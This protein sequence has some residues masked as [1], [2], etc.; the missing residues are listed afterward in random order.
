MSPCGKNLINC[1]ILTPLDGQQNCPQMKLKNYFSFGL[2]HLKNQRVPHSMGCHLEWFPIKHFCFNHREHVANSW[3]LTCK[4]WKW[5]CI[6]VSIRI[7]WKDPTN[8]GV[9]VTQELIFSVWLMQSPQSFEEGKISPWASQK[10]QG[11]AGSVVN[12]ISFNLKQMLAGIY[13]EEF[14]FHWHLIN[15]QSFLKVTKACSIW[16]DQHPIIIFWNGL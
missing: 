14:T 2:C 4:K 3:I 8:L 10:V 6:L 1:A 7:L 16:D 13:Q 11:R 9:K 15:L 5:F 12:G